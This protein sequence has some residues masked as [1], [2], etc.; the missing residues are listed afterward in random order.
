MPG[1]KSTAENKSPTIINKRYELRET[2]GRG[3]MG[4]VYRARDILLNHTVALKQVTI[5]ARELGIAYRGDGPNP[6]FTLAQEFATLSTMRHPHIISVFDFGFD[7]H[8]RPYFTMEYIDRGRTILDI[9]RNEPLEYQVNL[10]IQMLQALV[11]LHR[12]AILHRD[13][14]PSN[15]LVVNGQL[16]LMDFG[17]SVLTGRTMEHLT[18]TTAGTMAYMA[19]EL[20][21]G[22]PYSQASDLYGVGLMA[23]ELLTGRFPY[24]QKNIATMINDV[25]NLQ[26][27]AS[28]F[29]VVDKLVPVLNRLLTK[30]RKER[31]SDAAEV[32]IDLCKA[33]DSPLPPETAQIRESFL[34][35]ARF[36]GREEEMAQLTGYLKNAADGQGMVILVGGESGVGKSRLMD[37]LRTRALVEGFLV[38]RGQAV[39]DGRRPY[40]L[41]QDVLR[42]MRLYSDLEEDEEVL[43][44]SV[45]PHPERLLDRNS[46]DLPLL[47]PSEAQIRLSQSINR[48]LRG[49]EQPV[50]IILED[51]QWAGS[52]SI[53]LLSDL[54]PAVAK[55]PVLIAGTFRDEA[56][57]EVQTKLALAEYLR[58]DRLNGREIAELSESMLGRIGKDPKIIELLQQ[59]TE[60]NAF[61]L[62]EVVRALAEEAGQLDMIT[63]SSIPDTIAT[64]GMNEII[65]QR[66]NRIP[67]E[68]RPLL[69][70]AS[71]AGRVLDLDLLWALEPEVDLDKWL[72]AC[73]DVTV[74]EAYG[75][76]W[77]F[78]HDKLREMIRDRMSHELHHEFHRRVAEA[79]ESVHPNNEEHAAALA[80]HW[81]VAGDREKELFY[82]EIAGYQAAVNNA[83]EEAIIYFERALELLSDQPVS[84]ERDR[85][86]LALQI[87][88]GPLL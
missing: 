26:V 47:N 30:S 18:Q 44:K 58:I 8:R 4:V 82:L 40:Q 12:R 49:V 21:Q 45:I 86:E 66:L 85:K 72:E 23:L 3:G 41:W 37:E 80:H 59:E 9:G 20:F 19:P 11:Y 68:A 5:P 61:F 36:V 39:S 46:R 70:L 42:T 83:S 57:L 74:L 81:A 78:S 79:L 7:Q 65:M 10:F 22:E 55:Q 43:F 1:T 31:Y 88:L 48:L 14:K 56:P 35:A 50:L 13:M 69:Q 27:D 62:V 6:A 54:T 52:E 53:R 32:I 71:V 75:E 16:K 67:V 25:L 51:M 73:A 84:Q 64:K 38:M 63:T 2:L 33:T 34:Q 15:A 24:D 60:G 76:T 17:L 29:G 77:R 28:S 87:A